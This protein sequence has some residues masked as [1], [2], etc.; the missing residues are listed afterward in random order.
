M[1]HQREADE[2][3]VFANAPAPEY[4]ASTQADPSIEPGGSGEADKAKPSLKSLEPV[5]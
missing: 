4:G 5:D 1:I 3:E 2:I